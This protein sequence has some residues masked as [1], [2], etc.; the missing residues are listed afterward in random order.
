[1]QEWF[2][3]LEAWRDFYVFTGTAAATLMGLMFVVMSLGQGRLATEEGIQATR[4]F[5][6]PI[7]VF[8]AT[9]IVVATLMLMP[10]G[11]PSALGLL[12]AALA[13]GGLVFMIASGAHNVWRIG[14]LG[15]DDLVWYVAL[16]YV[17]YAAI[18]VAAGAIWK[19]NTFGLYTA[20]AAMLLLLLI[21][22][23]NAWDLVVYNIQR[24]SS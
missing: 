21:G 7:V 16:P 19:A 22:I 14:E 23:R 3:A 4:G 8:F 5:F 18:G 24:G 15:F 2:H 12:L 10:G 20:A 1:M 11:A 9:I 13:V 17:A 6:T